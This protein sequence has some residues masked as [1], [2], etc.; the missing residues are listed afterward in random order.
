[1]LGICLIY[2]F[3]SCGYY[4]LADEMNEYLKLWFEQ[5]EKLFQLREER[6]RLEVEIAKLNNL[7]RATYA[8]VPDEEKKKFAEFFRA[9]SAA[10]VDHQKG[11]TEAVRNILQQN[12]LKWLSATEVRDKLQESGFDFGRYTSN[13]LTSIHSVLKRFKSKDVRRRNMLDGTKEYRW[14]HHV[15][16][17]NSLRQLLMASPESA[18]EEQ[19]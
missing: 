4:I 13:P 8:L 11:M 3:D 6:G 1:M 7:M 16:P 12:N 14:R 17:I 18:K 10:F 9:Y 2:S 15:R 19:K 5:K